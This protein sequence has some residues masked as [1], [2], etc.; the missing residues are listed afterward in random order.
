MEG[1]CK[2][3]PGIIPSNQSQESWHKMVKKLLKGSLRGSHEF[4][5]LS[6]LPRVLDD[7]ALGMP[8]DLCFSVECVGPRMI[9]KALEFI[10]NEKKYIRKTRDGVLYFILRQTSAFSRITHDLSKDYLRTLRGGIAV[11]CT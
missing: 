8:D 2:D 6:T 3:L 5:L 11:E 10:D 7:D 1:E 4:V 9:E